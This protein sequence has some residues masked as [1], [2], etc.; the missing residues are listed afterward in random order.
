MDARE[1]SSVGFKETFLTKLVLHHPHLQLDEA[2]G[3]E[4]VVLSHAAVSDFM[5]TQIELAEGIQRS[6][7]G[8]PDC[9]LLQNVDQ[10]PDG[11]AQQSQTDPLI[12]FP[13][14]CFGKL[15]IWTK[16]RTDLLMELKVVFRHRMRAN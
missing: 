9:I 1:S 13:P 16:K 12:L 3:V 7:F 14:S 10:A 4:A 11:Q 2:V 5:T 15:T 8:I 6:D